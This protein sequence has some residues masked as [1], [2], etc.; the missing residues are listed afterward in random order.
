M[1]IY[2]YVILSVCVHNEDAN[3]INFGV[4]FFFLL[5]YL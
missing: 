1:Y 2:A 4:F 3:I 5:K